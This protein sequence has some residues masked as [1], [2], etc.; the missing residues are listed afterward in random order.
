ML[1]GGVSRVERRENS[2][3]RFLFVISSERGM[4]KIR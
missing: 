4:I 2:R 1:G 3:G